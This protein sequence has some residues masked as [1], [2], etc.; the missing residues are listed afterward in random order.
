[1]RNV[2]RLRLLY[3]LLFTSLL[4]CCPLCYSLPCRNYAPPSKINYII[5]FSATTYTFHFGCFL[6]RLSALIS[7]C[8]LLLLTSFTKVLSPVFTT[9]L[10]FIIYFWW[11]WGDSHPRPE[12]VSLC[13]IQQY[14]LF[15]SSVKSHNQNHHSHQIQL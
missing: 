5:V 7:K 1:M 8:S 4:M 13:F 3:F 11:R 6:E 2:S 12:P 10:Y 14:L 15:M 9:I